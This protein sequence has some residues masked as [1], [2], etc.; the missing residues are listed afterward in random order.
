MHP[1]LVQPSGP[2]AA[3]AVADPV[4]DLL[5]TLHGDGHSAYLVGGCVRDLLQHRP[6]GDFDVVTDAAPARVLELF[7]RAIP[8]GLRHGTVMVP[9]PAGPVDVTTLRAGPKLEDD[10]AH[11]DFTINAMAFDPLAVRLV[12]PFG[13]QRDL[14][15]GCLRAVGTP[16][17]RLAEGPVRALRAARFAACLPLEV[18]PELERAMR[19]TAKRL[20]ELAPERIRRELEALLLGS[21]AGLALSLLRRTGLEAQLAAGVREDAA[22][23]VAALPC[24]LEVRLAAWLRG[25]RAESIL[26]RLR[27][28]RRRVEEVGRMLRLHPVEAQADPRSD[29]SLRRLIRRAGDA[30]PDLLALRSA[31]LDVNAS[32]EEHAAERLAALRAGLA[33]V[34]GRGDLALRRLDLALDGRAVMQI[35]TCGPG[36][37]VGR[38]L[39]HLTERVLDDPAFNTP[40]KLREILL[41][42]QAQE[43]HG[44]ARRT[45]APRST[46]REGRNSADGE[47]A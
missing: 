34:Q 21:R 41:R 4:R 15:A 38:A 3:R 43:E 8:I 44:N 19:A 12:D 20:D 25:T 1:T 46:P 23:V 39:H 7:P 31:E 5:Q 30:L 16:G 32:A 22:R 29:A 35:L 33:R 37:A 17:E 27:F 10:L 28:A 18:D 6:I 24:R 36:P 42:W 47:R 40:E 9:T 45:A 14:D 13:G 11:R 2:A 26:S